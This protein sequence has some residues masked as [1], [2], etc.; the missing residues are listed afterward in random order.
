[1]K[2][3]ARRI[4]RVIVVPAV[5]ALALTACGG[6]DRP[7]ADELSKSLKDGKAGETMSM[8]S[9]LPDKAYDCIAKELVDSDLSDEALA[10]AM[11]GKDKTGSKKDREIVS[12]LSDDIQ[13][14]VTDAMS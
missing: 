7:T 4:A 11:E 9:S 14:C 12:G 10:N 3:N 2:T 1:M 5:C 8:P 6:G 13:K